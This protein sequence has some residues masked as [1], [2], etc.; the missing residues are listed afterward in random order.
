M[1]LSALRTSTGGQSQHSF[2]FPPFRS[3][4]LRHHSHFSKKNNS[5]LLYISTY[6]WSHLV[7]PVYS[8]DMY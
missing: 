3:G 8:T 5:G 1:L 6:K 4:Y 7:T 2:K